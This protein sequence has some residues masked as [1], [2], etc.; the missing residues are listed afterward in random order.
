M[1]N[2]DV[3]EQLKQ[4]ED[5]LKIYEVVPTYVINFIKGCVRIAYICGK[6][7]QIDK[8]LKRYDK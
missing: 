6:I 4:V 5:A 8:Q 7:E 3:K 1:S 2:K